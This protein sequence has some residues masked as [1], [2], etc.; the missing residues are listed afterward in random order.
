LTDFTYLD[1]NGVIA[2]LSYSNKE[3]NIL[4]SLIQNQPAL[5]IKNVVG[6]I[7]LADPV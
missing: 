2:A 4:D 6:N 5:K 7:I 1:P 3:I